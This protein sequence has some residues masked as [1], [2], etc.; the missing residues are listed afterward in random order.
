[1]RNCERI[2]EILELLQRGWEKVPDWRF[3]Q[4]IENFKRYIGKD[5]IFYL[6]DEKLKE[7][8]I[9]FFDLDE[10]GNKWNRNL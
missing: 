1:M 5:D 2:P 8:L 9:L 3:G 10:E 6:E 4:V 7:N